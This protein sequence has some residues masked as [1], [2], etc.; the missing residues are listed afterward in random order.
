L[1]EPWWLIVKGEFELQRNEKS[2]KLTTVI[3]QSAPF[4]L[5]F[6]LNESRKNNITSCRLGFFIQ[7]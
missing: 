1:D 2:R 6:Q 7:R 3:F 4:Q 5:I